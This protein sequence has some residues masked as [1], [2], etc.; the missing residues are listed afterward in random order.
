M[1][2]FA[3]ILTRN[4]QQLQHRSKP[5]DESMCD[6]LTEQMSFLLDCW[7]FLD[8]HPYLD[9]C[10][11]APIRGVAMFILVQLVYQECDAT[12][13]AANLSKLMCYSARL[14]WGQQNLRLQAMRLAKRPH[15]PPPA[16]REQQ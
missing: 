13:Q 15:R 8:L 2:A 3:R 5:F 4:K 10:S 1:S 11:W 6:I 7:L 16:S 14:A 12:V 9:V